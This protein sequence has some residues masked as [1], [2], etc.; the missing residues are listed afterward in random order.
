[1]FTRVNGRILKIEILASDGYSRFTED[2]GF[3]VNLKLIEDNN[4]ITVVEFYTRGMASQKTQTLYHYT[5]YCKSDIKK[6][7]IY[8]EEVE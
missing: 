7:H 6:I 1:M 3:P 4:S 2:G 5:T 8:T